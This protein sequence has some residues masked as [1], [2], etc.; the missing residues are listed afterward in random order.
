MQ[1]QRE[2][3]SRWRYFVA[4]VKF[5]WHVIRKHSTI[6]VESKKTGRH[7]F[8]MCCD[9]KKVLYS[10]LSPQQLQTCMEAAVRMAEAREFDEKEI[11]VVDEE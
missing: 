8:L 5:R 1:G 6:Q 11:E 9:C 10:S 3:V 2:K 4:V 7:C